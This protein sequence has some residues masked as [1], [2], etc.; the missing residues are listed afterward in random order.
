MTISEGKRNFG[1]NIK[2]Q[3]I[4][5]LLKA[6]KIYTQYFA[7]NLNS[8]FIILGSSGNSC[9]NKTCYYIYKQLLAVKIRI[10]TNTSTAVV[11]TQYS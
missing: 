8:E 2:I 3:L 10:K 6:I 4:V 9:L 1:N 11:K 7:Y 5:S